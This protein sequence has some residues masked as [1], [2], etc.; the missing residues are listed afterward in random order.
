M[1]FILIGLQGFA[2]LRCSDIVKLHLWEMHENLLLKEGGAMEK[3][4]I[5]LLVI[6]VLILIVKMKV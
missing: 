1:M 3:A 2:L 5:L 6:V 4:T